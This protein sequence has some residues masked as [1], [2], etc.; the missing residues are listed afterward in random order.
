M[1]ARATSALRE[2][3]VV[4]QARSFGRRQGASQKQVTAR[5]FSQ[6]VIALDA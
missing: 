4:V 3:L 5:R 1:L 6:E 2:S